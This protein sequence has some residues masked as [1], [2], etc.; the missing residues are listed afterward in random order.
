MDLAQVNFP[1]MESMLPH[2]RPMILL[3]R[4]VEAGDNGATCEVNIRPG[5]PFADE[6]GV[7]AHVG[8]EYMAQAIGAL[9]GFHRWKAGLPIEVGFLIGA[10]KFHSSCAT[11]RLG[12]TLRVEAVR[13]WGENQL[14]R[15]ECAVKDAATGEVLQQSSLSVFLPEN[16]E[17]FLKGVKQ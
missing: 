7:P 15:C 1:P 9:S 3:D 12:Q 8:L 4:M 5:I 6:E 14:A 11:F 16:L 2:R 13:V 17:T 10:P